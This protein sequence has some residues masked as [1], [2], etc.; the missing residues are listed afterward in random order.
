MTDFQASGAH[1]STAT[2]KTPRLAPSRCMTWKKLAALISDGHGQGH[3]EHYKPWLRITKRSSS[4]VSNIGL[5]PAPDLGRTHHYLSG[6]EKTSILLLKWLGA[7]DVRE[8]YPVWPWPHLHPMLGLQHPDAGQRLK[9]LEEI[10]E[11]LGIEHGTFFGTD[12]PYVATLDVLSTWR[13]ASGMPLLIAHECKPASALQGDGSK[14]V[15]ERLQLTERYCAL[16]CL[17][18]FTFHA[19]HLPANLAVNLD[20]LDPRLPRPRLKALTESKG[21]QNL[22]EAFENNRAHKLPGEILESLCERTAMP[23]AA[24]RSLLH[25]AI[26]KQ[27]VD[28]DLTRPLELHLPLIEGGRQLKQRMEALMLGRQK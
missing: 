18:R 22:I 25:L 17:P 21:Y 7:E 10:A 12:I 24:A 13:S 14:R 6:S 16:A 4:P 8:Q 3:R 19:E 20:A 26:W 11:D 27:D 15:L 1:A 28:H 2:T 23:P 5:L 9:G